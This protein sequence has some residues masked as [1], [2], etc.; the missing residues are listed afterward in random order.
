MQLREGFELAQDVVEPA[1]ADVG[2]VDFD[3]RGRTLDWPFVDRVN[4]KVSSGQ[5]L[6]RQPSN[7]P[8]GSRHRDRE[9]RAHPKNTP[10]RFSSP[11]SI[12]VFTAASTSRTIGPITS[13]SSSP[14][15]SNRIGSPYR[16]WTL[17]GSGNGRIVAQRG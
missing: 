9:R 10:L 14:R 2:H 13:S 12:S 1:F 17:A 15:P 6:E 11:R 5:S 7:R 3:A 4:A 16:M 8:R